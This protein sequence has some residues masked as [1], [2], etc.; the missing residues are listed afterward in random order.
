[1]P[2]VKYSKRS[3][4]VQACWSKKCMINAKSSGIGM[5]A[6][7]MAWNTVRWNVNLG[8]FNLKPEDELIMNF[9]VLF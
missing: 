6:V 5:Q 8:I 4:I 7:Q 3:A 9:Y 1:M 2:F